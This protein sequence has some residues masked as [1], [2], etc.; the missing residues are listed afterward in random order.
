MAEALAGWGPA[1]F[2]S[3]KARSRLDPDTEVDAVSSP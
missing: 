3:L 2:V 1:V